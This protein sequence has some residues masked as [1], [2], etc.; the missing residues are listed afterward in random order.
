MTPTA[1]SKY[2]SNP[3]I[4]CRTECLCTTESMHNN[5]ETEINSN[6]IQIIA[7]GQQVLTTVLRTLRWSKSNALLSNDETVLNQEKCRPIISL[8]E[9]AEHDSFDDCWIILYDRVYDVTD[10]LNEVNINQ[11]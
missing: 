4:I 2:R 5:I 10:F 6:E 11:I 9:V 8:S 7:K 3:C 1:D